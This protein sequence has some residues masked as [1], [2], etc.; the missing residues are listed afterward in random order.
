M[1]LSALH[2]LPRRPLIRVLLTVLLAVSSLT[3]ARAASSDAAVT[4]PVT[5]RLITAQ[6]GVAPGLTTLSAGLVLDLAPGWKTY[7][8][9]PG[10][11]GIPPELDWSGSENLSD[12]EFQWP[13]PTRFSAFGIENFGYHDRV[14]F[15]LL[16][17]LKTPGVPAAL[18][19]SVSMLVCSDICVPQTVALALDI[20]AGTGIDP[21]S[22]SEIAAFQARVPEPGDRAGVAEAG[23]YIKDDWSALTLS[24]RVDPPLTDPDVFVEMGNGN[25]L[26]KPDIRLS[27]GGR[28]LWAEI[29]ILGYDSNTYQTPRLT[30]TDGEARAFE[31]VPAPLAAA[32][33]APFELR[34]LAPAL[35]QVVWIA[36]TAFLG[37][38]I[39]NV[40]PCVLPVLSIKLSSALKAHGRDQRAQRAGFVMAALGVMSFMWGLAAI[41]FTLQQLGV[42][43]GWGLQFQ[44]PVFL[45]LMFV[46]LIVFSANLFGLFEIA[47]PGALQNRM[48]QAG[49]RSG[50]GADFATGLFGAVMATPCSA[51]FLG[52]AIAFAL[53]GRGVD[54]AIV[55][56]A[57]GLGLALPYLLVAAAPGLVRALPRPGRWMLAVK[58]V[59]GA[60]LVGTA[61]WLLWVLIGVAGQ[62]AAL[63]VL[64]L[65]LLPVTLLQL[66]RLRA[67]LRLS[68]V[69]V[70]LVLPL[71]AADLLAREEVRPVE[72][73]QIAWIPFDRGE[74]ARR[75]SRGEVVFVDVTADWCLTCKANKLLV[76]ERDP[77]LSALNAPGVAPMLADWTRPDDRIG[78]FLAD[79]GRYGI[80]FNAVYGPAA[81]DGIVLSEVLSADDLL[82]ALD[83]AKVAK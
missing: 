83:R 73:S 78:Q 63:A 82:A 5:A 54:I 69:A 64:G 30:V 51:P 70:S 65:A 10:E 29:P 48:A 7:W 50:L 21:K 15:P 44:N 32:P 36:L 25:A 52:T 80:P 61:L 62:V 57:L 22:A 9:S 47:L 81:P 2:A 79:N 17:H 60:L 12:V 77:V 42:A 76:L 39:L 38:L 59:L 6:D 67:G 28:A 43:V 55:F 37:G 66:R 56:T 68:A 72:V 46:V 26:G 33:R 27:S 49:G 14:V 24:L 34:R 40:M 53:A 1:F 18:R 20:P 11:V 35:D 13:A 58:A 16:V 74:I 45:A 23:I 8:R 31:V 3:P 75:V 19:A 41:L 4:E 71:F